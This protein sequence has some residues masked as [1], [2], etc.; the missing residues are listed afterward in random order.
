MVVE[1]FLIAFDF[2]FSSGWLCDRVCGRGDRLGGVPA[3]NQTRSRKS[4]DQLLHAHTH[5][6]NIQGRRDEPLDK[7]TSSSFPELAAIVIFFPPCSGSSDRRRPQGKLCSVHQPQ[8]QPELRDAKVD[9]QWRR[10]HRTLCADRHRG[11]WA[12]TH[13]AT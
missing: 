9:G 13:A 6:G 2:F 1:I 4:C 10:S 8:L 12:L 7:R 3:A 5:K 11:W